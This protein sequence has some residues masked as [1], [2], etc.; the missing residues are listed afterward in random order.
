MQAAGFYRKASVMIH[1]KRRSILSGKM[2][3]GFADIAL[4]HVTREYPYKMDH[5]ITGPADIANPRALHPVFHGSFD[6]HSCVH[7]F[8]LLAKILRLFPELQQAPKI[9]ALFDEHLTPSKI[10]GELS[11]L[12]KPLQNNFERPY[13]WAWLLMLASEFARHTTPEAK[14]WYRNL[15]PLSNLLAQRFQNYLPKLPFPIRSGTHPNTAFATALA[16]EYAE[17]CGKS[18]LL[19]VAKTRMKE[20]FGADVNCQALEPSGNDFHS[21][22]LVEME[23]MRRVLGQPDFLDWAGRFLPRLA[24]REPRILMVPVTVTDQSDPQT[25]HLDGLNFSRAWCWRSFAATLPEND[26]RR[27]I[28]LDAA[29]AHILASLP[30]VA[31]DY[32]VEHWLATYAVLAL[33]A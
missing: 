10:A 19:A 6:W 4:S 23:C 3:A 31:G 29:E 5:V 16:I 20:F 17:V 15:Q 26:A 18:E 14:I 21:P 8:W 13:G 9:R 28:A 32:M 22:L 33:T 2:A 1:S 12:E 24:E 27:E 11:Y 25:V 7:S 30:N